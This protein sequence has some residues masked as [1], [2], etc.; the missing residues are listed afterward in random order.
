MDDREQFER[1][2]YSVRTDPE[3][4]GPL[5]SGRCAGCG[6]WIEEREPSLVRYAY[7]GTK[8]GIFHARCA[9]SGADWYTIDGASGGDDGE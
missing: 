1:G 2:D 6:E 9:P 4:G 5:H 3:T 7:N 8:G